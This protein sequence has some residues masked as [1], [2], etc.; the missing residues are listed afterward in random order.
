MREVI[1]LQGTKY[2]E[3]RCKLKKE[4]DK[5]VKC[6]YIKSNMSIYTCTFKHL[7]VYIIAVILIECYII[8]V[9]MSVMGYA[10][11]LLKYNPLREICFQT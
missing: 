8:T 7:I 6:T 5:K 1:H 11:W 4:R 9:I 10:K 3:A 2:R